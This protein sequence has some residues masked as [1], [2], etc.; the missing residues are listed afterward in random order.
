MNG[1]PTRSDGAGPDGIVVEVA[2][3]DGCGKSTLAQALAGAVI[4]GGAPAYVRGLHSWVRR[5]STALAKRR[6]L[7][8]GDYIGHEAVEFAVAMELLDRSGQLALAGEQA[9]MI[10][11][12][13]T[14][15]SAAVA[16]THRVRNLDA[17]LD[18]YFQARHPDL[19]VYLDVDPALAYQRIVARR[20][21]DNVALRGGAADL[22]DYRIGFG[23]II[24]RFEAAGFR[25]LTLDATST[26]T[27]LVEAVG[28]QIGWPSSRVPQ[29]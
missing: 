13:Y 1:A 20:G 16:A 15:C 26:T 7:H 18:V 5:S 19:I 21:S 22:H 24:P 29:R 6:G 23:S 3:I 4:G 8:R 27:D 17:V 14:F 28:K 11:D 2:G 12:P 9:A 25:I 10:L